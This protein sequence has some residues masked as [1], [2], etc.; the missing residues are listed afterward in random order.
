[1]SGNTGKVSRSA[2]SGTEARR[3]AGAHVAETGDTRTDRLLRHVGLGAVGLATVAQLGRAVLIIGPRDSV[4]Y[5]ILGA[6]YYGLI[7][8]SVLRPF[9]RVWLGHVSALAEAMLVLFL[10]SLEPELDFLTGML[11]PVAFQTTL[12]FTGRAAWSWVAGLALATATSLMVFLGPLRGLSL[13][14]IPIAVEVVLAAFVVVV[15]ELDEARTRGE[16]MLREL[17]TTHRQL[18]EFADQAGELATLEQ[19]ERVARDLNESVA[20]TVAEVLTGAESARQ[21]LG[22]D[23]PVANAADDE[24]LVAALQGQT[25]H[26]LA[27]MR[28]LIAELRPAADR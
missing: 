18:Q 8:V 6:V 16:V 10:L 17:Q 11:A 22:Q 23:L 25:Q 2:V 19:R 24:A 15:R 7:V 9:R 28:G 5:L 4:P 27:Q 12:L 1:M 26:A 13:A 20:G 3:A 21:A 14:L